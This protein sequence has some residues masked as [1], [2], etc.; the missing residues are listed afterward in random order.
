MT[1]DPTPADVGRKVVIRDDYQRR[2]IFGTLGRV[3][4]GV[5]VRL[6]AV[7]VIPDGGPTR[8]ADHKA[9]AWSPNY[10]WSVAR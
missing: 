8:T 5:G 6:D 1:A 3:T 7:T 4:P 9:L 10:R 2:S